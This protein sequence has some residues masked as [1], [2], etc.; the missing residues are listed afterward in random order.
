MIKFD[1]DINIL[2]NDSEINSAE[3]PEGITNMQF[4]ATINDVVNNKRRTIAS[5]P[6]IFGSSILGEG[7]TFTDKVDY[8]VGSELSGANGHFQK[9]YEITVKGENI[10]SLRFVF[11][12]LHNEY[13]KSI[14][15]KERIASG[16]DDAIEGTTST[17]SVGFEGENFYDYGF[18]KE[19]GGKIVGFSIWSKSDNVVKTDI[20]YN[21]NRIS[22]RLFTKQS[23]QKVSV[24]LFVRVKLTSGEI[25]CTSPY[26][27]VDGLP[28]G[29]SATVKIEYWN[30][31]NK[32]LKLQSIYVNN[33]IH[34]DG[35]N[36]IS[37]EDAVTDRA[38]INAPSYGI[39]SNSARLSFIDNNN[40]VMDL[41][42]RKLLINNLE[43]TAKVTDTKNKITQKLATLYT[44][45]WNY[46]ANSKIV[47][48]TVKDPLE[49]LQ[50][51]PAPIINFNPV[52]SPEYSMKQ[53]FEGLQA[54]TV[55]CGI[56]M[57]TFDDLP[58][59]A[60]DILE[61]TI[62]PYLYFDEGSLW[63]KWNNFCEVNSLHIFWDVDRAN[64][65]Y[66]A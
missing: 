16:L 20:S 30:K 45:K 50:D 31:A 48:V 53:I 59:D 44:D 63:Q 32:P 54:E 28:G 35:S 10:T 64:F 38:K 4:S 46:D 36:L 56:D 43:M 62:V 52:S 49:R 12:T 2:G 58:I 27:T 11:D 57:V 34:I 41:A 22:G 8:F 42:Q 26:V 60:R 9:P 7:D 66:G 13:P 40:D 15:L 61:K 6:F 55:R 33:N 47:E 18:R 25:V 1:A 51:I 19:Y 5:S 21:E 65:T 24:R 29:N 39:V 14:L 23:N 3:L 17:E 37:Y